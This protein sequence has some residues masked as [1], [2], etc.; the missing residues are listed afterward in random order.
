MKDRCHVLLSRAVSVAGDDALDSIIR[1]FDAVDLVFEPRI[2][3]REQDRSVLRI[4]YVP[5]DTS[6][7]ASPL[8]GYQLASRL[9]DY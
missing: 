4:V 2:L 5:E 7:C 8:H 3:D 1:G 6:I 9:A